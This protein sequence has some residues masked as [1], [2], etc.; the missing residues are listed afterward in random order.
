MQPGHDRLGGLFPRT[1]DAD[2][3][4]LEARETATLPDG[5][6]AWYDLHH[7]EFYYEMVQYVTWQRP[8]P[9]PHPYDYDYYRVMRNL[10]NRAPDL[11]DLE[12]RETAT[13]PDGWRAWY[14]PHHNEFYYELMQYVTWR[15]PGP[16]P[17]PYDYD[18]YRVTPPKSPAAGAARRCPTKAPPALAVPPPAFVAPSPPEPPATV[19]PPA[20]APAAPQA[21]L[22]PPP[23]AA[24]AVPSAA[25]A[26]PPAAVTPQAFLAPPTGEIPKAPPP[27]A[28][29]ASFFAP[30]RTRLHSRR[31]R[32]V[33]TS[34]ATGGAA[35]STAAT[36]G[37][38]ASA[39]ADSFDGH[40]QSDASSTDAI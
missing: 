28:V 26:P 7:N 18:Y 22:A 20:A 27:S 33:A 6:R 38:A 37:T 11:R 36:G 9:R 16:R 19:P 4:D 39:A 24:P 10:R 30:A 21:A 1:S 8:G 40:G 29:L 31:L 15:R 17:H 14:D 3:R 13:L 32:P 2:L 23:A 12:A 5:W 34:A 35:A 25:L